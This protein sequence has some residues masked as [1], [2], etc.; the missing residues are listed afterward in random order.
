MRLFFIGGWLIALL[1]L[2]GCQSHTPVDQEQVVRSDTTSSIRE[3][4]RIEVKVVPARRE[5]FAIPVLANGLVEAARELELSIT[6]SGQATTCNLADG[7]VV[8]EGDLLLA[9]DTTDLAMQRQK[10]RIALDLAIEEKNDLIFTGGGT[11]GDDNSVNPEQLKY[12]ELR[13]GY[14]QAKQQ[15]AEINANLARTKLYAPFSGILSEVQIQEGQQVN[16]GTPLATLMAPSSYRVR[17]QVLEQDAV[18]LKTGQPV[19]ILP[20]ALPDVALTGRILTILPAVNKEGL[21]D[22]LADFIQRHDKLLS[23]MKVQVRIEQRL[24]DQLIIPKEALVL[25]SGKQVVFTYDEASGLAKWNYV[26]VAHENDRW[27]AIRDG[28]KPG[29]Q[30]IISNNANLAHDAE[31][32]VRHQTLDRH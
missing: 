12:F 20:V 8:K 11:R 22:V 18:A 29:D 14:R 10:Q 31:V 24:P 4:P 23:G 1:N 30:V 2:W 28:L 26:D 3:A 21:V 27:L 17:L 13:S 5:T 16:A 32:D 9:L 7:L 19:I 15:L 6:A 25:R